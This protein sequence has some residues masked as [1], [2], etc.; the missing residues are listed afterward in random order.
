M[1]QPNFDE[2]GQIIP[3]SA[4]ANPVP[5]RRPG[6]GYRP[7]PTNSAPIFNEFGEL[8]SGPSQSAPLPPYQYQPQFSALPA[9][10]P[11]PR[12]SGA[13]YWLI[14]GVVVLVLSGIYLWWN[15]RDKRAGGLFAL[16]AGTA[17]CGLFVA[18]L[19]WIYL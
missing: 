11:T 14:A 7:A 10:L 3:D 16:A 8:V 12:R 5:I 15:R 4:P 6:E 2:Y 13:V 9:P 18:G 19:R 1:S 17:V